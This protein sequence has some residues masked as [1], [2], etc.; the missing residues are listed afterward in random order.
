VLPTSQLRD[1]LEN[2]FETRWN[3]AGLEFRILSRRIQWIAMAIQMALYQWKHRCMFAGVAD[4]HAQAT[5]FMGIP[6]L[7]NPTTPP[8]GSDANSAERCAFVSYFATIYLGFNGGP[9]AWNQWM[10]SAQAEI[11]RRESAGTPAGEIP[12]RMITLFRNP[13][14]LPDA[15]RPALAGGVDSRKLGQRGNMLRFANALDLYARL[16]DSAAGSAPPDL[17]D[18]AQRDSAGNTNWKLAG[19]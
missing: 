7:Q 5:A 18:P 9:N 3:G 12:T 6:E 11:M 13:A 16:D 2:A 14:G 4:A 8:I 19:E 17:A 10:S 15:L 1:Y